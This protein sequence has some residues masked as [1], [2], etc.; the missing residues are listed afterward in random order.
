M[1]WWH[2]TG[3]WHLWKQRR[4]R[5]T[6]DVSGSHIGLSR[7]NFCN[8][9]SFAY[10]DSRHRGYFDWNCA[11]RSIVAAR[12]A[13]TVDFN[14]ANISQKQIEHF[15]FTNFMTQHFDNCSKFG[16]RVFLNLFRCGYYARRL[17]SD[18]IFNLACELMKQR[19]ITEFRWPLIATCSAQLIKLLI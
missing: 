2:N 1:K 11:W 8:E 6:V 18:I 4:C 12:A 10:D 13:L 5:Q 16:R 9:Y 19:L 15:F 14:H 7:V 3:R 17:T